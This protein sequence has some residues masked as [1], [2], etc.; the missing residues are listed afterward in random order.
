MSAFDQQI[1]QGRN[2]I[3][4]LIAKKREAID[5][6]RVQGSSLTYKDFFKTKV[7]ELKALRD[8]KGKKHEEQKRI[9]EKLDAI[10]HER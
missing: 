6:G 5:G 10:E 7:E 9:T 1:E 3:A 2:R 8:Q 4:G